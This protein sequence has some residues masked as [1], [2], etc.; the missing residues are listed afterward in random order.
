MSKLILCLFALMLAS[1]SIR[2]EAQLSCDSQLRLLFPDFFTHCDCHYDDWS[3]WEI[4]PQ[5][6][7]DVPTWQC[8][9]GAAYNETRIQYATGDQCESKTET[10]QVCKQLASL[11]LNLW[12]YICVCSSLYNQE[13]VLT[14]SFMYLQAYQI[15]R[16][17]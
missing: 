8:S 10:Q 12:R 1:T 14:H 7:V 17:D 11:C 13:V 5:S 3:D 4:E 6:T 9:S 15:Q 2:V 16:T